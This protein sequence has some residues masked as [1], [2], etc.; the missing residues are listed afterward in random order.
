MEK[1]EI[2]PMLFYVGKAAAAVIGSIH[3]VSVLFGLGW[4][5][6]RGKRVFSSSFFFYMLFSVSAG[7]QFVA[8]DSINVFLKSN[9]Y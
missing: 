8:R 2:T 4:N 5:R 1:I 3:H 6:G 7:G 9:L